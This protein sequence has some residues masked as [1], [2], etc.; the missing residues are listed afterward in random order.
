MRSALLLA[1]AVY[2]LF[3]ATM[4][5]GTMWV[6]RLFLY[7]TWTA[8]SPDNVMQHFGVPTIRATRFFTVVV[9]PMFLSGV[10]LVVTEWGEGLLWLTVVCLLGIVLLTYVGQQLIIP[11]NKRIRG[12]HYD[13]E[14]ELRGLLGRWMR[15]NDIR[16]WGSTV[17]WAAIV[18]YLVAK[19]DL[20]GA[21]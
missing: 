18:A 7:P 9:P 16:F 11:V 20:L 1:N 8:L 14:S 21:L 2:F 5:V 12:G 15:L 4:Y 13:G 10:I 6:L 19:P 3:G 17:T